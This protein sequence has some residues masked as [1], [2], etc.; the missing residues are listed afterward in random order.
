MAIKEQLLLIA[1]N[2]KPIP[3]FK[4]NILQQNAYTISEPY[5][6]VLIISPWNYPVQLSLN[7]L[8]GAIASGNCA[9][10]KPSELSQR[11]SNL[12][13]ELLPNYLDNVRFNDL[14]NP[15]MCKVYRP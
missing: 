4:S 11:T 1:E 10:L 8:I 2:M 7:P 3:V 5:G 13:A 9:I 15:E 12:L 14:F 6:I